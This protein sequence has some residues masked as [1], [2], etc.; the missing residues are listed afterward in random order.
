MP[1]F[2]MMKWRWWRSI[3]LGCGHFSNA[4][5][6]LRVSLFCPHGVYVK[7]ILGSFWGRVAPWLMGDL[8]GQGFAWADVGAG[9]V[10]TAGFAGDNACGIEG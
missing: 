3:G 2:V 7:I 5:Q 6:S 1:P 10:P 8:G 9:G 4:N